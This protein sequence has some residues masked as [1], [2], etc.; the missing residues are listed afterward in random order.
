MNA[1]L[2]TRTRAEWLD[3]FDAAGVPAGPVNTMQEA[4]SHPQ[5]RARGMVVDLV[6][7]QAGATKALGSPV[8]FSA[9]PTSID[10]PAPMLGEHTDEVLRE[11]GYGGDEIAVLRARGAI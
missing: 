7:P 3:A 5:A 4:L 1:V 10:R 9:T 6:H 11:A 8:H 2:A